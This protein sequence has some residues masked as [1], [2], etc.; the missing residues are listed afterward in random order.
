MIR[1]I[2]S[3]YNFYIMKTLK[4]LKGVKVLNKT[5][6][7]AIAGGLIACDS[8]HLCPTGYCCIG[9]VCKRCLEA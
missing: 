9:G 6:Q 7:K 2:Y 8:V 3:F 4:E 1:V 5:E